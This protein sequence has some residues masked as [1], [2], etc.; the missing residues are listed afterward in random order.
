VRAL[1][2]GLF[3]GPGA[4]PERRAELAEKA[5][6][7]GVATLHHWLAQVD[8]TIAAKID[9][10]DEKRIVRALEVFLD[11]GIPMSVHQARHDHKIMPPRYAALKVGLAPERELLYQRIARRVDTMI[12]RGLVAEVE[13]LRQAGYQ[14]PMRSQEAIGYAEIHA[15]LDGQTDLSQ[16]VEHIKRNSRRYARRQVSWYRNDH[17]VRWWPQPDAVDH[18]ELERYLNGPHAP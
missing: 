13:G 11:T 3:E 1:L 15:H 16:A 12:D 6:T 5:A 14:P 7:S 4:N 18:G 9:R 10:N 17:E 2:L 8:P